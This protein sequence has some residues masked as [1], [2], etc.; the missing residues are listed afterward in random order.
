MKNLLLI[1]TLVLFSLPAFAVNKPKPKTNKVSTNAGTLFFHWGYNR[2]WYTQSNM[3]FQGAGYDFTMDNAKAHDNP[4]KFG[5]TYFNPKTITVPQFNIRLGYNFANNWAVSIGYDH[6]KYLFAD[7]NQVILNGTIEP[8]L[9]EVSNL[10]GTYTDY[11]MVTEREKFHYENSDGLNYLRAEV[12]RLQNIYHTKDRK[13]ALTALAGVSV[14]GILSYNDFRFAGV[15]TMRTISLS[16]YGISGHLGLRFEFFKHVY[17]QANYGGGF[18][19]QVNVKNR[20]NDIDPTARTAQKFGYME[21]SGV[22]GAMFYIRTKNG[23]N[24]CPSW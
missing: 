3:H 8:G 6:M 22:L 21:F 7:N 13:F 18:M 14:G 2:S 12:T 23:C 16:G 24:T 5:K 17:L 11:E 20:P 15:N 9:D 10:S 4:Q 19:H 1:G